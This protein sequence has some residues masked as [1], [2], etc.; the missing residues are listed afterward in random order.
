MEN[1]SKNKKTNVKLMS[2]ESFSL[3]NLENL[4]LILIFIKKRSNSVS[5][6]SC[7]NICLLQH[8]SDV[9]EDLVP[10]CMEGNS[11]TRKIKSLYISL[12]FI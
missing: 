11:H 4:Y 3:E 6:S 2:C 10:A 8:K 12:S 7:L 1:V 9:R 5:L